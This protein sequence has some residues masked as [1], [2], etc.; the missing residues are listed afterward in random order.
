MPSP[1]P[2]AELPGDALSEIAGR[3]HDAADFVR[4]H[5]VCRPWREAPP[6]PRAPSFHPCLLR[7]AGSSDTPALHLHSPFSR[8]TRHPPPNWTLA[9]LRG[10]MLESPDVASG[11]VLALGCS[12]HG[13]RTAMLINPLTGDATSLPPLP[14]RISP[15]NNAWQ[16]TNGTACANGVI[17]LHKRLEE[18]AA[19]LLRPGQADWK[20]IDMA[21]ATEMGLYPHEFAR[22]AATLCS[23]GVLPG[24]ARAMA[25]LPPEP[26][27]DRYVLESRGELL[28]IDVQDI[29]G[30]LEGEPGGTPALAVS[31]YA[32]EVNDDGR[33]PQWVKREQ[34]RGIDR[35]C[36][37][38]DWFSRHGFAIDGGEFDDLELA[39]GSAYIVG[40]KWTGRERMGVVYRYSFKDG[41]T[42][43]VDELPARFDRASMWYVPRPR[44]S[45]LRC[46]HDVSSN[47]K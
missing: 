20:D 42:A 13:D 24:G 15:S 43:V 7:E 27:G 5:A 34:G 2:W 28:C 11:R 44:I 35:M 8:K 33:P 25:E 1:P 32:L 46:V 26:E 41:T 10:K 45:Q 30:Y 6:P 14:H 23:S 37:F 47:C 36:L 29:Q 31:A 38:L 12:H 22:R 4:F 16:S 40:K 9:A 17:V 18:L 21:A 3:L 19:I 39:G